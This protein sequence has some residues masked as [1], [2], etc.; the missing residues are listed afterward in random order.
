MGVCQLGPGPE[1]FLDLSGAVV[2]SVQIL[3]P[4]K[5][6]SC[7]P[8]RVCVVCWTAGELVESDFHVEKF[9]I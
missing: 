4:S 9:Q 8:T 1:L 3:L 7:Q 5:F 2:R 6:A